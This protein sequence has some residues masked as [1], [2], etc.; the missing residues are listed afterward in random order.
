MVPFVGHQ[1][2][3]LG[4]GRVQVVAREPG[5]AGDAAVIHGSDGFPLAVDEVEQEVQGLAGLPQIVGKRS[6]ENVL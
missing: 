3:N 6:R 1:D 2:R 4:D 5:H